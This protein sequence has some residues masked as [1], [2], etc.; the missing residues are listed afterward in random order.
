MQ[1]FQVEV[2]PGG[3]AVGEGGIGGGKVLGGIFFDLAA[4]AFDEEEGG[5]GGNRH[6]DDQD[7]GRQAALDATVL[8]AALGNHLSEGC[9]GIHSD[10]DNADNDARDSKR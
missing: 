9:V 5:S 2:Q 7:E 8:G 4:G 1:G 3:Y 10:I 6:D